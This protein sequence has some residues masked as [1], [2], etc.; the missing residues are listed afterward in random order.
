V[1]ANTLL[2]TWYSFLGSQKSVCSLNPLDQIVQVEGLV[3]KSEMAL[4]GFFFRKICAHEKWGNCFSKMSR[5][6]GVVEGKM[7]S[8]HRLPAKGASYS[9]FCSSVLDVHACLYDVASSHDQPIEMTSPSRVSFS[10]H[11]A[12]LLVRFGC[13]SQ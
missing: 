8:L 11:D 7:G 13:L 9:L 2:R 12:Y 4:G 10:P 6:K 5:V 3:K 1:D